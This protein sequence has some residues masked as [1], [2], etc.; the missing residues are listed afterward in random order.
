M[1]P[2][3]DRN[4]RFMCWQDTKYRAPLY[5]K[6]SNS[7]KY[8]HN[9]HVELPKK[10]VHSKDWFSNGPSQIRFFNQDTIDCALTCGDSR[11]L[12]LNLADD[13]FP[14]GCVEEGAS[15][16]EEALFRRSNYH[17][18]LLPH[19]YPI[20]ADEAV[21]SP[22]VCVFKTAD[23]RILQETPL[24][25]LDFVACPAIKYPDTIFVSE[26]PVPDIVQKEGDDETKKNIQVLQELARMPHTSDINDA[27]SFVLTKIND[28]NH[29][30]GKNWLVPQDSNLVLKR[31]QL[32]QDDVKK[33]EI[34]IETIIQ[35]AVK[36]GH[37][38]IIFGAM[39]CGAWKNPPRHVAEIFK[40]VLAKH[41]GVIRNYYFAILNA[42]YDRENNL[43][44][45]REA[46][47]R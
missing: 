35:L 21:Y 40:R 8:K 9:P 5:P 1:Q 47:S 29:S 30:W 38:T 4:A 10:Y 44:I 24:P 45:F 26:N 17:L 33:L 46:F 25:L 43:D 12:V 13:L 7:Y 11:P 6:P 18:T 41:D 32:R 23:F 19:F 42:G 2:Q 27:G 15:S 31:Q 22:N 3:H 14:G 39:G 34:K 37:D 16:Q 36:W 20:L 28:L